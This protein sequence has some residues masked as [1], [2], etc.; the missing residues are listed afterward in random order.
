[1][2][3][4]DINETLAVELYPA[5]ELEELPA[6][7]IR[8]SEGGSVIIQAAEVNQLISTLLNGVLGLVEQMVQTDPARRCPDC[9]AP[10]TGDHCHRCEAEHQQAEREY[11]EQLAER[12]YASYD[13]TPQDSGVVLPLNPALQCLACGELAHGGIALMN[14]KVVPLCGACTGQLAALYR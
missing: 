7:A 9:D 10:M 5:G 4:I 8:T 1:M 14:G 12:Q 3:R 2:Q 11:L 13:V 6:L